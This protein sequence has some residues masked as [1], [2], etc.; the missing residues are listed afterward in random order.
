MQDTLMYVIIFSFGIIL[1]SLYFY[2]T[3][4][5]RLLPLSE[6]WYSDLQLVISIKKE[7]GK[8]TQVIIGI[9]SDEKDNEC[10]NIGLELIDS[11]REIKYLE[12]N[13]LITTPA[14]LQNTQNDIHSKVIEYKAL[15]EY[16]SAADFP[17]KSIRF[18]TK[19]KNGKKYKSHELAFNDRWHLY[20][21]DSGI[22][23]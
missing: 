7:K 5:Q 22:Y 20:K 16:I 15:R 23:N 2:R 9:F 10:Q 14:P 3:D 6:Q 4:K 21:I 1:V 17:F 11:H 8:L 13:Q 18:I 12:L 19:M